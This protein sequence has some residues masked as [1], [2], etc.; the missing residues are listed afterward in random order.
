M[1]PVNDETMYEIKF[2]TVIAIL[3]VIG[4][5]AEGLGE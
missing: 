5:L 4:I 1:L 2:W 3:V